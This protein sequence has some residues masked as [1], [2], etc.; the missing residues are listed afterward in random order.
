MT[1]SND[2]TEVNVFAISFVDSLFPNLDQSYIEFLTSPSLRRCRR[3]RWQDGSTTASTPT[4][5]LLTTWL[6]CTEQLHYNRLHRNATW[7]KPLG[8]MTLGNGVTVGKRVTNLMT[9]LFQVSCFPTGTFFSKWAFQVSKPRVFQIKSGNTCL[10][11]ISLVV[12][13]YSRSFPIYARLS[14]NCC[15]CFEAPWLAVVTC[16]FEKIKIGKI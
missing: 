16:G 11:V 3:I 10:F 15:A 5:K 6:L 8:K 7:K 4:S 14:S 1:E 9:G 12:P 2:R 13:N